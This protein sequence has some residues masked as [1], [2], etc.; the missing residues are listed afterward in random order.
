MLE[1][2]DCDYVFSVTRYPYPI[3]R[4]V[5][6]TPAGRVEM[7]DPNLFNTRSQDL[8]EAFHDAGQFYWGRPQAWLSGT[9]IFS[10]RSVPLVLPAHRVQDI[11]TPDDWTRAEL[12]FGALR[13]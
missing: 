7:F 2:G 13:P 5:R 10:P 8:E 9:P 12:M 11:D 6:I 4:A 1:S 3:Q